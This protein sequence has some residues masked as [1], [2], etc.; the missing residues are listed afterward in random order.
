ALTYRHPP[1]RA[2]ARALS[3]H[4]W[5]RSGRHS[6][7]REHRTEF[8]SVQRRIWAAGRL[9]DGGFRLGTDSRAVGTAAWRRLG[10]MAYTGA[11][12]ARD[13]YSSGVESQ[14][15]RGH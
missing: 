12:A 2:L 10:K 6:W 4:N 5:I 15:T 3:L 9:V 13:T 7:S 1:A 11:A 14:I 8:D